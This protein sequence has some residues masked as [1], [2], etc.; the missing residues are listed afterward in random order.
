[1]YVCFKLL[2]RQLDQ[3]QLEKT[4]FGVFKHAIYYRF[5]LSL[6]KKAGM[7]FLLQMYSFWFFLFVLSFHKVE[8]SYFQVMITIVI[9]LT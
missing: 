7:T 5:H 9:N 2:T 4:N 8:K 6:N 1:M 3:D